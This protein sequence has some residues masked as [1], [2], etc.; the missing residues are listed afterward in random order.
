MKLSSCKI[1]LWLH[2]RLIVVDIILAKGRNSVC[3]APFHSPH[4]VNQWIS[5][6]LSCDALI[7]SNA[8][9]IH[10]V[11]AFMKWLFTTTELDENRKWGHAFII[12]EIWEL[13]TH[14]DKK[15]WHYFCPDYKA[16]LAYGLMMSIDSNFHNRLN[17][18]FSTYIL[19]WNELK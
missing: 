14:C 4:V 19:K 2:C 16:I 8:F 3:P 18:L 1:A 9:S 6:N 12:L 17:R 15:L 10:V 5:K 7:G 13:N 11:I